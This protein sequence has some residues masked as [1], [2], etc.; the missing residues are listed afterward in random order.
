[1]AKEIFEDKF[2]NFDPKIYG[3]M[4]ANFALNPPL[5]NNQIFFSKIISPMP[6]NC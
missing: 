4:L 3:Q 2:S 6:G 1:M 5:E